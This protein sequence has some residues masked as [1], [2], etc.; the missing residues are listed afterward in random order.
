MKIRFTTGSLAG[1][2]YALKDGI[3]VVG[4]SH[5]CHVR[6]PKEFSS[7]S[8]RHLL[9]AKTPEGI[10]LTNNSSHANTTFVDGASIPPGHK[11][12][13]RDGSVVR[14]GRQDTA[15]EFLI[16][17]GDGAAYSGLEEATRGDRPTSTVGAAT[18]R[19]TSGAATQITKAG[20]VGTVMT[21]LRQTGLPAAEGLVTERESHGGGTTQIASGETT[22]TAMPTS[23]S[24]GLPTFGTR[25]P[26]TFSPKHQK[27]LMDQDLGA[28]AEPGT[29]SSLDDE[30]TLPPG[31]T[32]KVD[33]EEIKKLID[34]AIHIRKRRSA[35]RFAVVVGVFLLSAITYYLL[36][37]RPESEL[38]WPKRADGSYAVCRR[39][40]PVPLATED[41]KVSFTI[42][43]P[44][45]AR[46]VE[47]VVSNDVSTTKRVQSYIGSARDVPLF[48]EAYCFRNPGSVDKT[49]KNRFDVY[50]R[51]LEEAGSWN[52]LSLRPMSFTGR[53][54]GVPYFEAKYLRTIQSKTSTEQRFGYLMFIAYGD[55]SIVITR[56]IP[57]IEQW[58]GSTLLA[59]EILLSIGSS[60]LDVRWEGRPDFRDSPVEE[61]LSEA[62]GYLSRK[63]PQ[64]WKEVEFLLQS[65]MIKSVLEKSNP[66]GIRDK[67]RDLREKERLEFR[68]LHA[69]W[70]N[71]NR[72][73]DKAGCD[74]IIS[75]AMNVFTKSD[76]RSW[77][78]MKGMWK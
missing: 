57:A 50:M 7:V 4:R 19:M 52:V 15:A 77:L 46:M 38:T 1:R 70:E 56:E 26:E 20:T 2:T 14:V 11:V 27:A 71:S 45:D 76:R 60:A 54:N 18:A 41:E 25:I 48:V 55:L 13:L 33:P 5:D 74:A 72:L 49:S 12:F 6:I 30:K 64:L 17:D 21:A 37:P 73:G 24:A 43:V 34:E 42:G 69:M 10:S 16:D 66:S 28:A 40:I 59:R 63:T 22:G 58:R 51:G 32:F 29:Q 8:K 68:R 44:E 3:A 61:L 53:D 31:G 47:S 75:E 9:L 65:A 78:L 67:L 39:T 36:R 23:Q 62:D 35:L